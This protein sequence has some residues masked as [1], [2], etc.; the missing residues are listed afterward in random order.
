MNNLKRII[1]LALCIMLLV[2]FAVP[3]Q[4]ASPRVIMIN[5]A[6]DLIRLS[7][8]CRLDEYSKELTVV[9]AAD[10]DMAGTDFEPIPI[11]SGNFHG[12]GYRITGLHMSQESSS[13]GFFRILTQEAK[14]S[15]L[16]LEGSLVCT[17]GISDTGGIAGINHGQILHCS[18]SGTV[19][20][21][22][23]VGG[24]AGSNSL[25]GIIEDCQVYGFF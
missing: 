10:I 9:L 12:N 16:H 8:N 25:T 1:S 18:Y 20:G 22:D 6:R 19:S 5:N 23:R 4:V 2:L 21:S 24:I 17:G 14:V 15:D 3:A 7:Q 13:R 11:F